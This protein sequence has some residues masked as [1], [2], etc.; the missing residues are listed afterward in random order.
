MVQVRP[1]GERRTSVDDI[2]HAIQEDILSLRLRPGDKLSEAEVAARF[3]VSRQPVRDAFSRLANLDL[4]LIRPQRATEVR[5]FSMREIVKSRFVRASVEKEVLRLAAEK[6]DAVG[7]A[8]L[9][10]ALAQQDEAIRRRDVEGFGELDYDFHRTL[11]DIAHA[12]FAFDV[13]MAEKSK[14]DRLCLLGLSKEDR[15]PELVADHRAIAEAV[16]RHDAE[17]AV[18]AGA[19]HL[20]RLDETIESI[21]ATN[22]DYFEPEDL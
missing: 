6:C 22:Q 12:D 18:A 17:T 4:L 7:A 16:E 2:F 13:I 1:A 8:M 10:A 9:K 5:R 11:C 21:S 15:M 14:V 19:R 3:G 20:S